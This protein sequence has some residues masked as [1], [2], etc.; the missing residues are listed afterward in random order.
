[1]VAP[2]VFAKKSPAQRPVSQLA[3]LGICFALR[4]RSLDAPKSRRRVEIGDGFPRKAGVIRNPC[5][6]VAASGEQKISAYCADETVL[7]TMLLP[8]EEFIRPYVAA[9]DEG[10]AAPKL[11][12][13]ACRTLKWDS[14]VP[15]KY[16]DCVS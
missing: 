11:R 4:K 8:R 7:M 6:S 9:A 5:R 14:L 12:A 13:V 16:H 15:K 2:T 1:M 3:P 10:T